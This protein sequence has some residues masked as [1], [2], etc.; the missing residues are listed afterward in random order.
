MINIFIIIAISE[1]SHQEE[2]DKDPDNKSVEV[3]FSVVEFLDS[4]KR[5][6]FLGLEGFAEFVNRTLE[7][8][9]STN[10]YYQ[11]CIKNL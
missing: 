7:A 1:S 3:K 9:L 2:P 5:L 10:S 8:I 4:Y 11:V 6:S